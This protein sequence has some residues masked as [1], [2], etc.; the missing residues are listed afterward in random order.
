VLIIPGARVFEAA[1]GASGIHSAIHSK[2]RAGNVRGIRAGD[3]CDHRSDL[4]NIPV[5]SVAW[6]YTGLNPEDIEARLT[7]PYEKGLTTLV[8][9][10]EHI[11]SSSYNG[12]SVVKIYLQPGAGLD[13][14]KCASR[15][16]G[17]VCT[18]TSSSGHPAAGDHQF[19]RVQRPD[20]ATWALGK[21]NVGIGA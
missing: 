12:V 14:A 3:K 6:T 4:I 19:Q 9:N 10:I 2:I 21:G 15:G 1:S 5:I 7:T 16:A 11:E 20:C 17:R 13:T 18:A 8:D